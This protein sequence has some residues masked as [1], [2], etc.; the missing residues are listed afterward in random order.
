MGYKNRDKQREFQRFWIEK[1][2][3]LWFLA[4]G[5]CKGCGSWDDLELDHI[6]PAEKTTHRVWSL[7]PE[8]RQAELTK[9]Q[10]LCHACHKAKTIAQFS[11]PLVHGTLNGYSKH[12]C[13]C[14]ACRE[15]NTER[16]RRWKANRRAA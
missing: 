7:R 12:R 4:N 11:K 9:C 16:V 3:H 5:P 1:V 15:A 6:D 13:R 2:R 10:A 8:K 14:D